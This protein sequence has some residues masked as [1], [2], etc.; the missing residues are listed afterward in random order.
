MARRVR[1]KN[2]HGETLESAGNWGL[3]PRKTNDPADHRY[4]RCVPSGSFTAYYTPPEAANTVPA[5]LYYLVGHE[6]EVLGAKGSTY[7][8]E[9]TTLLCRTQPRLTSGSY[10]LRKHQCTYVCEL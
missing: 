10:S 9:R 7:A 1:Q 5:E 4:S 2:G 6:S 3:H 8:A